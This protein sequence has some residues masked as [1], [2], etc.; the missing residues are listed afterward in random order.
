[1]TNRLFA[2]A[3]KVDIIDAYK[4]NLNIPLFDKIIDWG[5]FYWL[6]KPLFGLMN[7]IYGVVGNWGVAILGHYRP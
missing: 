6:T 2:G 4:D 3:K 5:W 7:W 1:M